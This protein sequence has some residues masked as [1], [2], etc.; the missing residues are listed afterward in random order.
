MTDTK[1]NSDVNV[2]VG[3]GADVHVDP[4]I[5]VTPK[6]VNK[7]KAKAVD[8]P[9]GHNEDPPMVCYKFITQYLTDLH[10]Q[11]STHLRCKVINTRLGASIEPS[12][13][14]TRRSAN[15]RLGASMEL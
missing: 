10:K 14:L 5:I 8:L 12:P 4:E 9:D 15:T 3:A 2:N 13:R 6:K 1:S 11:R 7:G